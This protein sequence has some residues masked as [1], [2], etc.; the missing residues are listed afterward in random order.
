[1]GAMRNIEPRQVLCEADFGL[2]KA[3]GWTLSRGRSELLAQQMHV[4]VVELLAWGSVETQP[5]QLSVIGPYPSFPAPRLE[6]ATRADKTN[7]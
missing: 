2:K 6:V 1:M 7:E 5:L 4:H 3:S